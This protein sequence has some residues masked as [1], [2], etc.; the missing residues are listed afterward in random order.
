MAKPNIRQVEAFNAV[1][2]AG[3]VTKA[4]EGLFVSQP[5]VS[6]LLHAFE[7]A[8]DLPLFTR[9]KGRVVPTPEARQLFVE[10]SKL[11]Q[12]LTRVHEAA[13][14]IRELQRGEISIVAFPA[15]SMRLIP[16]KVGELLC[17]RPD[18]LLSLF[19]RTSRSVENSMITRAADF[20][21]SLVPTSNPALHCEPFTNISMICALRREH[22]LARKAAISLESIAGE[23][24]VALGRDDLSYPLIDEAFQ[25]AGLAMRPAA[26]VQMAD[27]ACSMVASGCGVAIVPS[28]VSF[29]A[30]FPDVV[31]RPLTEP[32]AMTTWLLTSTYQ[33][34]S[35]LALELMDEIRGAVEELEAELHGTLGCDPAADSRFAGAAHP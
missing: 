34:L 9:T 18:V 4:A 2:K 17:D 16:R 14:A 29:E 19:T 35:Q 6:K 33:E 7:V 21:I 27:A 32:I 23:R 25:R 8:C 30:D 5:A 1:M 24:L 13:R 31:F 3:S 20:G 11:E 10:T 22:P 28:L 12:G 15:M 26:E